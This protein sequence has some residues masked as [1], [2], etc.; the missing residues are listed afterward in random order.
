[1][2]EL[3]GADVSV[4]PAEL[5]GAVEDDTHTQRNMDVLREFAATRAERQAARS[6]ALPSSARRSRS[7]ATTRVESIELV[8]NRLEEQDGRLVAVPTDE[9]ETLDC[10]LVFRSVGLSRRRPPRRPVRRAARHDRTTRAGA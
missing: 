1:M 3:A 6:S 2:G 9:H 8:R 7:T 5:E 4:D 10:G